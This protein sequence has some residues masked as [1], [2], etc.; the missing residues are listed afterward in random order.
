MENYIDKL[1]FD[2]INEFKSKD[3]NELFLNMKNKFCLLDFSTRQ[4]IEEFLN[5]FNYWGSLNQSK[6]DYGVF[7]EKAIA[8][9]KHANDLVWFYNRLQDYR[10]K[11]VLFAVLNNYYNFDFLSLYNA[12]SREFFQYFDLDILKDYRDFTYVDIGSFTGDSAIN[13]I[14]SLKY[15]KMY[16]FEITKEIF[17]QSKA[18]LKDYKNIVFKNMAVSNYNGF[19]KVCFNKNG[20]SANS[21]SNA[22][23]DDVKV[24]RLDDEINEK[25]DIIKMDIEGGERKALLGAKRHIKSE[26]PALL[27]AI[28]HGNTDLIQL[29]KLI[30]RLNKNYK[31]F[32]RYFGGNIFATEIDLIA[33]P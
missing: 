8:Y 7:F 23:G 18:R 30:H 16:L 13:C 33:V 25:I 10:S 26:T 14:A 19:A 29:P 21:I 2:L 1:F 20:M 24:V 9:K 11:F 27:I 3:V 6:G 17:E 12:T 15:K 5:K 22:G 31:F 28:Y 32:L 4:G